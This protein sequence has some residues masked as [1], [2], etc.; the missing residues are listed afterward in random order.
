M[1]INVIKKI[2]KAK[3]N[4][5]AD[6]EHVVSGLIIND[7]GAIA[8][9][10]VAG[11]TGGLLGYF[12][13]RKVQKKSSEKHQSDSSDSAMAAK[14]PS[15]QSIIGI[16]NKR[17][18]IYSWDAISGRAKNL[19]AE[20]KL[21]DVT[22]EDYKKGRMISKVTLSFKDGGKKTYDALKGNDIDAFIAAIK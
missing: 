14:I 9:G 6:D 21:G 20:M 15:G 11:G 5:L 18:A 22:V 2:E 17:I 16:T 13:G 12:I 8:S 4:Q 3:K 19:V 1:T 7:A 10:A